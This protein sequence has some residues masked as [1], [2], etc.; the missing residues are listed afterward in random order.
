MSARATFW[1]RLRAGL[2]GLT[3]FA[4]TS[5]C[6]RVQWERVSR[7]SPVEDTTVAELQVGT[8][9]L[10]DC[11]ERLGA[12]LWVRE[13]SAEGGNGAVCAWG[14]FEADDVGVR[15]S[16]AFQRFVSA[17]FDYRRIN[18]GMEGLVGVFDPDWR[19]VTLERG[20][21]RDLSRTVGPR[22]P[23]PVAGG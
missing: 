8:S 13:A 23:Q 11:L 22:R 12:P 19:L 16:Y 15:I 4:L 1:N 9:T 5:S 6:L 2:C 18:E 21:L 17:S 20:L 10:H 3:L 7:F 14:W